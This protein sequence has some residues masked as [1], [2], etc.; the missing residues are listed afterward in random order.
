MLLPVLADHGHADLA[1]RLLLR[2]GQPS[3]LGMIEAGAT[4]MWEY[5]DGIAPDGQVKGSLDHYS[6]GAVASFLHTHVAGLRLPEFP[7]P[8]W[9]LAIR[10]VASDRVR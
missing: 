4:T 6:K 2:T 10:R 9:R 5:W 8:D 1:Y 3:W 7:T